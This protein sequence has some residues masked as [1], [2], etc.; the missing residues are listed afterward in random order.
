[1]SGRT[2]LIRPGAIGD[3]IRHFPEMELL[4]GAYTEVWIPR[5][6]VPLVRFANR[7]RALADTGID[8]AGLPGMPLPPALSEFDRIHS[9]YGTN[10]PEFREAVAHLPF[11][12]HP[13]LPAEPPRHVPRIPITGPPHGAVVLHPFSGSAKKNWPLDHFRALASLLPG[14]VYWTCG[15]E[16]Q[17]DGAVRFDRLDDLAAWLSG[18]RLYIGNDSGVTHLAAAVGTP[19]LALFGPS[20]PAIWCPAGGHVRWM[21]FAAPEVV[22]RTAGEILGPL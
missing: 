14:P 15:P 22:A 3:C 4:R 20:D 12:F 16:E 7:V 21:R 1:V 9:W 18:A 6:L 13:A 11:T 17:L 19:V 10:R 5:P 2:L 8:L